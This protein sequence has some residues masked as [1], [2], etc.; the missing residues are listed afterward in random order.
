MTTSR[1]NYGRIHWLMAGCMHWCMGRWTGGR[2]G[3]SGGCRT[4][5]ASLADR[6]R[7]GGLMAVRTHVFCNH[8]VRTAIIMFALQSFCPHYNPSVRTCSI[9]LQS[10]CFLGYGMDV[11][12]Y[13][14]AILAQVRCFITAL[15]HYCFLNRSEDADR[16]RCSHSTTYC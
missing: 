5:G 10:S 9:C 15:L 2:I 13:V 7:V 14:I 16:N 4:A 3:R 1:M 11:G 8:S 6:G 12:R